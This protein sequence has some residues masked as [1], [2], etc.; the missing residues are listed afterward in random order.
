[1]SPYSLRGRDRPFVAAP[2]TWAEVEAG[3][4]DPL[5]VSQLTFEQVLGRIEERGDLFAG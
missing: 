2:L 4:E 3:A 5:D 1:M